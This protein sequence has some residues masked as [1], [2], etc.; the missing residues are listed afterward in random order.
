MWSWIDK[1][2]QMNAILT[3]YEL[4]E[5][6]SLSPLKG[7]PMSLLVII[8]NGLRES[9]RAQLIGSGEETG[10]RFLTPRDS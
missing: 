1:T 5:P 3:A 2:G 4:I 8:A 10:I 9:G 6:D 7:A